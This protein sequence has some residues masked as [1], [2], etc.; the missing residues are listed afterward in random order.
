MRYHPETPCFQYAG[1]ITFSLISDMY[2]S[3]N[4]TVF[5]ADLFSLKHGIITRYRR[6]F[7]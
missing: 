2:H 6:F 7:V 4:D 5:S 3:G 1:Y